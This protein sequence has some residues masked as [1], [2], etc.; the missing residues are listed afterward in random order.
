MRY[1]DMDETL[2]YLE[3]RWPRFIFR[4][5]A[6]VIASRYE[7]R[8]P[9]VTDHA[10]GLSYLYTVVDEDS[11]DEYILHK[12]LIRIPMFFSMHKVNKEALM[13]FE[14]PS[15]MWAGFLF[16]K[17]H[18]A[19]QVIIVDGDK[20]HLQYNGGASGNGCC[21]AY[22]SNDT[23]A[24]LGTRIWHELLHTVQL[25]A[26]DMLVDEGFVAWLAP[27]LRDAFVRNKV[28]LQHDTQMQSL[29]YTYLME[30]IK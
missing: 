25:P 16:P 26:D 1:L 13:P 29:F 2:K 17:D 6:Q 11:I 5:H 28:A 20:R 7:V 14:E 9:V 10:C 19:R 27:P 23:P 15:G 21:V 8:C 12:A 22:R 18:S 24:T 3:T 30:R 4:P